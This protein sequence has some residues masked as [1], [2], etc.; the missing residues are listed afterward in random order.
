MG[1]LSPRFAVLVFFQS[2]R[3]VSQSS[4]YFAHSLFSFFVLCS[5]GLAMEGKFVQKRVLESLG[6]I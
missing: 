1:T 2:V 6:L 3:L 4:G 5:G